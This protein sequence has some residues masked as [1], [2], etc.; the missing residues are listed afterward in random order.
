MTNNVRINEL[1]LT[2]Y[3][4]FTHRA[5]NF[6]APTGKSP[7]IH[8]IHGPNEAGKSTISN[9]IVDFLFGMQTRSRYAFLHSQNVLEVSAC[10]QTPTSNNALKRIN[11]KLLDDAGKLLDSQFIDTHNPVSYT[12]LT[13]P[14][15]LLV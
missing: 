2:R 1:E 15:I 11:K 4:H 10:L 3:G 13:L 12:H 7:D 5:L 8:I 14:T 6:P 9:A